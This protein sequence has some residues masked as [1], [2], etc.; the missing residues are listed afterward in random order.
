M[1]RAGP[2]AAQAAAQ[3]LA[4]EHP[5][6]QR[7]ELLVAA[8]G[9]EPTQQRREPDGQAGPGRVARRRERRPVRGEISD[10]GLVLLVGGCRCRTNRGLAVGPI[11]QAGGDHHGA[12]S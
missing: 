2:L 12:T 1:E 10:G 6:T 3:Q 9:R 11:G 7:P 5:R 8:C 4:A